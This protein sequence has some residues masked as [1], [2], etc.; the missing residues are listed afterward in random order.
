MATVLIVDDEKN[1]RSHLATYVRGLGHR[2]ETAADGAEALAVLER[3]D[4]DVVLSDVR[5]AGMDGVELLR[6]MRRRRPDAVVVLMTAYAT[7]RGAVEAMREGAY[8]YLVKPFE[9]DEVGLLLERILEVRGLR[10]ENRQLRRAV[11]APAMLESANAAMRRVLATARQAAD[12]AATVL[13]TGE[14]GTGKNVLAHAIHEWS[15]RRDGPFV[16]VACT[17]LSEHLLESELFGHVR[18]AG[19]TRGWHARARSS[20]FRSPR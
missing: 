3:L 15:P 4:V 20:P 19:S 9:L 8:D 14:S 18:G 11:E 16:V 10:R 7:V 12:S 1:I 5:M 2:A 6:E 13:L 17:T